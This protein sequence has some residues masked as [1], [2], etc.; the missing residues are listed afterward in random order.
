M[1]RSLTEIETWCDR[2]KGEQGMKI[3]EF[4]TRFDRNPKEALQLSLSTF[5]ATALFEVAAIYAE[6]I[7]LD[8]RKDL[9]REQTVRELRA[10]LDKEMLELSLNVASSPFTGTAELY[11]RCYLEGLAQLKTFLGEA[12]PQP[13]AKKV[14]PS[15]TPDSSVKELEEAA[16]SFLAG[17]LSK[18]GLTLGIESLT[19]LLENSQETSD[20]DLRIAATLAVENSDDA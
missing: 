8:L 16:S 4:K 2:Q 3:E 10:F 6:F 15:L 7:R 5:R 14:T 1:A 18:V 19:F 11:R 9:P 20:G 13:Q 17:D 12:A